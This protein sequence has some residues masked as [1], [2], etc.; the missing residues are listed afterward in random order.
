M[1][2]A[3]LA[4]QHRGEAGREAAVLRGRRRRPASRTRSAIARAHRGR[5]VRPLEPA[6][7]PAVG[8]GEGCTPPSS[9]ASPSQAAQGY[10][11]GR[12]AV[13]ADAAPGRTVRARPR[14]PGVTG[15]EPLAG[16]GARGRVVERGQPGR[17]GDGGE[18][19]TASRTDR[20]V[21]GSASSTRRTP[22]WSRTVARHATA[23]LSGRAG[24]SVSSATSIRES[25]WR[26]QVVQAPGAVSRSPNARQPASQGRVAR[27]RGDAPRG[28]GWSCAG[29]AVRSWS[30]HR[31]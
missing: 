3:V 10:G 21:G 30:C 2:A 19:R 27:R 20:R 31:R 15:E 17:D 26:D 25:S 29:G 7:G 16:R 1:P 13:R 11:S 4:G 5:Q 22:G 23:T 12:A 9:A 24:S 6:G 18:E 8:D 14:R 28:G